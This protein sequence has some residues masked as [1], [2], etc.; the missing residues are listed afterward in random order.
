[1][2]SGAVDSKVPIESLGSFDG[3]LGFLN[4]GSGARS[5]EVKN[6]SWIWRRIVCQRV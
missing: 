6:E 5:D 2:G 1:L 4:V 3:L